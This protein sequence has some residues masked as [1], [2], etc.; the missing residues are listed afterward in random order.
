MLCD[1]W[2]R[3]SLDEP[4]QARLRDNPPPQ[5]PTWR[6]GLTKETNGARQWGQVGALSH[7]SR[8]PMPSACP[9]SPAPARAP[10]PWAAP[11]SAPAQAPSRGA[12]SWRWR[13][14]R[15]RPRRSRPRSCPG[16][17]SPRQ[18]TKALQRT[19][20]SLRRPAALQRS[21]HSG[22]ARRPALPVKPPWQRRRAS[23][24]THCQSPH[25]SCAP[26]PAS[27]RHPL[28]LPATE[29]KSARSLT[30]P[31]ALLSG[32]PIFHISLAVE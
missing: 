32:G 30:A 22:A 29:R 27:R 25:P 15:R 6:L 12:P 4:K 19:H 10:E 5:N 18:R 13:W 9:P 21:L 8:W 26:L 23:R 7:W 3:A 17:A 2:R 24:W 31:R 28:P 16:W 14:R 1:K 20:A 11:A